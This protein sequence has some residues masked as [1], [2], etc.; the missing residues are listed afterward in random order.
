MENTVNSVFDS[1]PPLDKKIHTTEVRGLDVQFS[2]RLGENYRG[3][4]GFN[5]VANL[6]DSTA[7]AKHKYTLRAWY[8]AGQLDLRKD[9]SLNLGTRIDDYSNFGTE[10]NP[11]FSFLYKFNTEI[12]FHGALSRCFRVPTFNDLYYPDVGW[13]KGNADL[14][15]EKGITRELGVDADVNRYLSCGLN[16]YRSNYKELINWAPTDP[17][18]MVWQV[19]NIGSAIIDGI[20][21]ETKIY[22]RPHFEI[23]SMYTYLRAKDNKA[24]KYLIYRPQH[25]VDCSLKYKDMDGF[26]MELKGQ[27]TDR[28]FDDPDN[29]V[30]VKRFFVIGLNVSK[31]FGKSFTYFVYVDNLLNKKYQVIRDRPMPGFSITNSMKFEF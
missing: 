4:C 6:N 30:V 18:G 23:D 14:K 24:D 25:K 7:T 26:M 31:K 17:S 10:V 12:K 20:E 13:A 1:E 27:F 11:D 28:R 22:P 21:F 16:F 9:F 3:I 19:K 8:L 15:P 5:Y 29:M 2:K